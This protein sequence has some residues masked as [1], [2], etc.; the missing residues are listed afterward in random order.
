MFPKRDEFKLVQEPF[1][2]L[3]HQVNFEISGE[4]YLQEGIIADEDLFNTSA[5]DMMHEKS[6]CR[7]YPTDFKL[8]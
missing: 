3:I 4:L 1:I 2:Q 8:L 6:V 7:I 5:Y